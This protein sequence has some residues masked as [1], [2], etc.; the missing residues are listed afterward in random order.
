MSHDRGSPR[1]YAEWC[2]A[3]VFERGEGHQD[4]SRPWSTSHRFI[5]ADSAILKH[6]HAFRELGDVMLVGDQNNRQPPVIQ[7]LKDIHNVDRSAAVEI[8][9]R[10]IGQ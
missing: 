2:R 10:L 7:T 9:G 5:L 8:A 6:Q 1:R 3:S 4:I